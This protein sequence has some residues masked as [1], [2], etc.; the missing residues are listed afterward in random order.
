MERIG[1]VRFTLY[2]GDSYHKYQIEKGLHI[3][4]KRR[5]YIV[6]VFAEQR[7]AGN[8]LAVVRDAEGLSGDEMLT[9]AREMNY[10]ETT[11]IL[12]DTMKDGG[13]DV[14]I[15]TMA[16]EVPF[17]GHPTL[18]TAYILNNEIADKPSARIALNLKAGQIPVT[19]NDD[20]VLWMR[21]NAPEFG[22]VFDAETVAKALQVSPDDLDSRFP[23][24][25]V[26]TGLPFIIAP[27]KSLDA[28]RRAEVDLPKFDAMIGAVD[29]PLKAD[30][31]L[32]FCPEAYHDG[33]DIT[34]R[35][36]VHHHGAVE[37]PATG[38][39][40]GCLAGYLTKYRYFG[41]DVVDCRVGQGFYINR[42][43]LLMLKAKDTGNTIEVNVG[44][45]VM[46]VARG[47]LV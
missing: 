23:V 14:R 38:S 24:Q 45:R 15:F 26:S 34:A 18:G 6:D 36:F 27:L 35:C 17:A 44:G 9:I 41:S 40:N 28:V 20:G 1:T 12:S 19:F 3:M 11:F 10:S 31:I 4:T 47:E 43:S 21:Q 46:M 39:A 13:Y 33:N 7:Y 29:D 22:H 16:S 8:Q 2:N 32:V 42:P 30:A 37:D 5:F 25:S